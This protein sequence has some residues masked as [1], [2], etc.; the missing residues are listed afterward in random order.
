M[1][2]TNSDASRHQAP[3]FNMWP[4]VSE[5]EIAAVVA[6]LRSG[7]LTAGTG[8]KTKEFEGEFTKWLNAKFGLT[9]TNGTVSLEIALRAL[10]VQAGDEVITTPRSFIASAS[11]IV[12]CGAKP[13]FA[14]VDLESGNITASTIEQHINSRTKA[15]LLV[16]LGGMPCEMN[17]I[18]KLAQPLGIHIIEDCAQSHAAT[19]FGQKTGTFG[20]F[21]SFSFF[22]DKILSTGGEGGFLATNDEALKSKA[23]RLRE[24]GRDTNL[25][26]KEA[27][28]S[29]STKH[30]AFGS[31]HRLTEMQAALGVVALTQ[32]DRVVEERI[33]TS[34]LYTRLFKDFDCIR[35]PV[36]P[37]HIVNSR[38]RY[39][40]YLRLD[41]L[42]SNWSRNR[43]LSELA[44]LGVPCSPGA[45]PE[46]YNE[47]AFSG[48]GFQP[49]SPLA[50]AAEL[51]RTSIAFW[52]FPSQ[53]R[54]QFDY[55]SSSIKSVITR[56][57]R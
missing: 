30:V 2:S 6:V 5:K 54:E 4:P 51:G 35:D 21:G 10:G 27:P 34:R 18:L 19:Y 53:I 22:Q 16:H 45:T 14:D 39:Y 52:V 40:C 46:L 8:S 33:Q 23:W 7:R 41:Q 50:G 25:H 1:L 20:S 36:V 44:T 42:S 9:V 26:S 37:K 12:L 3:R 15:I 38:Y 55:I 56:A 57:T 28:L 11:A 31:N 24:H 13:V 29:R 49:S 17:E 43:I 47:P 48:T 32:L